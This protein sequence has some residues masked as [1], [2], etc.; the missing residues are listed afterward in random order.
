M[1]WRLQPGTSFAATLCRPSL[2]SGMTPRA[3]SD[4]HRSVARIEHVAQGVSHQID[5]Q[6]CKEDREAR[7][8]GH[9]GRCLQVAY[10]D[11]QHRAPARRRRLYA[12]TEKAERR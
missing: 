5:A 1:A 7:P 11:S 2:R 3:L 9:P 4:P 8:E 10:A 6:H 12:E